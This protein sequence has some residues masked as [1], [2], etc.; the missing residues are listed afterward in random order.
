MDPRTD[1]LILKVIDD[2]FIKNYSKTLVNMENSGCIKMMENN[3]FQD[4]KRMYLLF[5]RVPECVKDISNCMS[6]FIE[7]EGSRIIST[8][9]YRKNSSQL[10]SDLLKLREKFDLIV[11]KS[12]E[13]DSLMQTSMKLSFEKCINKNTKTS[14][15]LT[16]Y[17]DNLLKKDIKGMDENTIDNLFNS[18]ILLFRYLHNKDVFESF[19][20]VCLSRRLLNS[21]SLSDD[22]E[23]LLIKKLKI[24]CGSHYTSKIEGMLIDMRL[25]KDSIREYNP[26]IDSNI[27]FKVLTAAFWPQDQIPSIVLPG[28]FSSKM[29]KFRRFYINR[30]SGRTII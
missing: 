30:Y 19:Y 18:I 21:N 3:Q 5:S 22:A 4:L 25:S 1:P 23:K 16:L 2:C 6:N 9:D 13:N 24:E 15:A 10:M 29:E 8:S 14:I 7:S 28:D 11:T 12:F 26:G 17:T 20:K 27:E